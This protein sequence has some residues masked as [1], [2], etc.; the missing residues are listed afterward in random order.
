MENQRKD[1]SEIKSNDSWS[2]FKI[3]AEFVEAYDKMAK[4]GPCVAIFGSART[5]PEHPHYLQAVE[6]GEKLARAGYGVITG[7]GPGIMEAGNKG[8]KQGEGVSVGLNIDLP[9]EQFHNIYI[10][11]DHYLEFD[12]FFVRKVIFVKYS[13]AFVILPG[14]FGTLD[15][16][17][18][19]M[20]LVQTRKIAKRPIVLLGTAYW[21]GLFDWVRNV[22]LKEGYISESDL[23]LFKITDSTDEAL[24]FIDDF[25][26]SHALSPNF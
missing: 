9:F 12:Y 1:W 8:A 18:E 24:Q 20:T 26:S 16:L 5:K 7:G 6:I 23:S 15:E 13:Q 25:F 3:M 19:A 14:G 4:A 11:R 2:I 21:S 10:D 22:Q 17:F